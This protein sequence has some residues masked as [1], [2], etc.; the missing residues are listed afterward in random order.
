MAVERNCRDIL[1]GILASQV[2]RLLDGSNDGKMTY[3]ASM[4]I[5]QSLSLM[6]ST[7]YDNQVLLPVPFIYDAYFKRKVHIC[8]FLYIFEY[9]GYSPP[10][11]YLVLLYVYLG[12]IC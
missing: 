7:P 4:N 11:K 12:T 1:H 6:A 10:T 5:S 9:L 8:V 2:L 3:V